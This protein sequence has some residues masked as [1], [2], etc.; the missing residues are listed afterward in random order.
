MTD[1]EIK[2]AQKKGEPVHVP[3]AL[4]RDH[5]RPTTSTGVDKGL[6]LDGPTIADIFLGK[7]KKWN[8]PAITK[9]NPGVEPA[10]HGHHGRHRSDESG[11]T[12]GFTDFL[13][14]LQP[15][16]EEPGRRRQDR[17]VAD[18]HGRQGQ[19][20]RRRRGQ[21]DRRRGRLR[22]AGLRAAEQLHDRRGEE[23]VRQRSSR[24]RSRR[25]RR[26]ARASRSRPTCGFSAINAPDADGLPDRLAD[27]R[28]RLQGP[29]QGRHEQ[30][31]RRRRRQGFLDYALGDGQSVARAA[32]VRAAAGA[33]LQPR[34]RRK[35]D[36]L[37]VQRRAALEAASTGGTMATA[38]IRATA[39]AARSSGGRRS[40]ACP[41]SC[42]EVGPDRRSPPAILVLIAYFFVRLYVEAQPALRAVRRLR[43]RLHNNW[44]VVAQHLRRAAARRRHADHRRRSRSSSACRS[45]SPPRSTSTELCPRRAARRR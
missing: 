35:V 14:R 9:L 17:Q 34:R 11:T 36:G 38:V 7:V 39:A 32:A 44:D 43:L 8:D 1:D 16:V 6:K 37:T 5:G 3:T 25:P 24:R 19:R 41:T 21:A 2:A 10:R 28:R 27:V 23:Q 29:V 22:R 30:G 4:R 26:P 33:I 12:K 18:R 20:R 13:V 42:S 31:R 45:P 40:R 15:G